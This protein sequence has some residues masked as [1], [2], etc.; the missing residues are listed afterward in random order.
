MKLSDIMSAANLA[1]YAE[2]GL[3]LF[4]V[5]FLIVVAKVITTKTSAYEEVINIPFEA[6]RVSRSVGTQREKKS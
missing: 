6:D 5:A 1:V 3:V 4:L 2:I